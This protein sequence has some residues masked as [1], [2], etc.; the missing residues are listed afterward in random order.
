MTMKGPRI[1]DLVKESTTMALIQRT[2]SLVVMI[3]TAIMIITVTLTTGRT[4]GA[5]SDVLSTIDEDQTRI[6]MITTPASANVYPDVIDRIDQLT[7]IEWAAAFGPVVDVQPFD[8]GPPYGLR[9][10]W[11]DIMT[12]FNEPDFASKATSTWISARAIEALRLDGP[13]GGLTAGE[14]LTTPLLAPSQCRRQSAPT[15]PDRCRASAVR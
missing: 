1:W 3:I 13:A 2:V 15:S 8:G 14:L 5:E 6:F 10:A 11:G 12:G 4:A 7:G 9:P